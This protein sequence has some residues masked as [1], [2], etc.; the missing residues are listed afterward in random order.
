MKPIAKK[1]E[2]WN[3]FYLM[4]HVMYGDPFPFD[5]AGN[6]SSKNVRTMLA[7]CDGAPSCW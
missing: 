3:F 1:S 2:N 7:K 4:F 5:L 6:C